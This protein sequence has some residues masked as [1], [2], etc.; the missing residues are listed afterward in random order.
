MDKQ[1]DIVKKQ[2]KDRK[3]FSTVYSNCIEIAKKG[4][5]NYKDT[6]NLHSLDIA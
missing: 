5:T 4:L 1:N 2:I 3:N 6:A